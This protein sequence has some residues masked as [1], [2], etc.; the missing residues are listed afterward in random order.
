MNVNLYFTMKYAVCTINKTNPEEPLLVCAL[1]YD[2]DD[3]FKYIK[4][5]NSPDHYK[6]WNVFNKKLRI[7]VKLKTEE[8]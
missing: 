5:K 7:L 3:A 2:L 6:I 4:E 1:F 8:D